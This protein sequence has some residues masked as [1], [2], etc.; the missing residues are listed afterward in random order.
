[1]AVRNILIYPDK[2]LR[3]KS[4]S[5]SVSELP[6]IKKLVEDMAETMYT[7]NGLGLAAPQIGVH[8]RVFIIDIARREERAKLMVFINPVILEKQGK[9]KG[10][11]GCLSFPEIYETIPRA[12]KVKVKAMN[13]KGE[14]FELEAEELLAVAIQH[15]TDHLDGILIIDY[16]NPFRK[17]LVERKLKQWRKKQL[18]LKGMEKSEQ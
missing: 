12:E 2:R 8:K 1:M 15:E 11:E 17:K 5:V 14:E 4:E 9:I 7:A 18:K 10:E 3:I 13:L 6:E 16:L